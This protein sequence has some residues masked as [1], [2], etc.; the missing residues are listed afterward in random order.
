MSGR[1]YSDSPRAIYEELVR[2]RTH[3]RLVWSV[4]EDAQGLPPGVPTVIRHS[5][6]WYEALAT[7]ALWVDNQ[8][9]P[10]WLRKPEGTHYLQTWHGT[11]LKLMG[12]NEYGQAGLVGDRAERAQR[13][14]DRW[15]AV[16]APSEYFVESIVEAFRCRA[17]VLRFGTPRNDIL[18]RPLSRR[19]RSRRLRS[20]GVPGDGV[21]VLY[22]PTRT[23]AAVGKPG[24]SPAAEAIAA[25]GVQVLFRA[26]YRD[27][28]GP[29]GAFSAGMLDVSYVGDMADLLAV[30][31]V[32]V[33][34]YS[35]SMFDFALT[36][37]PTILYQ[38]AQDAYLTARGTY[39]DIREFAPGPI[40]T[41][42]TELTELVRAVASWSD[43]W[44][45]RRAEY[46]ALFGQYEEGNAAE[47][48]VAEYIQP[49]L[50]RPT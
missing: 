1:Q 47:R 26:H 32:L 9:L 5:A 48:V 16:V 34:D 7:A 33:T 40:A 29:G 28:A 45:E 14:V 35:S 20:L 12:W 25:A 31:D 50:G 36:D 10:A 18:L 21:T 22:A 19:E 49:R 24:R 39:F 46:R 17:E 13:S 38:G 30:A 27:T 2:Q 41:T 42:L 11:P 37:R 6:Q 15:D 3:A 4:R 23:G 44:S 8:G 43:E